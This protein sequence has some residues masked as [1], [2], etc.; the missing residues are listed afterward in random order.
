MDSTESL[1][2]HP[3]D[4]CSEYNDTRAEMRRQALRMR[5]DRIVVG[6]VRGAEVVDL[7]AALNTGHGGSAGTLHA[8]TATDVPARVEALAALGGVGRDAV[9]AQLVGAV[10]V[11][12]HVRRADQARVLSEIAVLHRGSD[13]LVEALPAV[14][15]GVPGGPGTSLLTGLLTDAGEQVPW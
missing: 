9:H 8:N 14:V 4:V 15:N 1:T 5:P 13:G 10:R 2:C 12:M 6:E 11:V 7:L 3:V